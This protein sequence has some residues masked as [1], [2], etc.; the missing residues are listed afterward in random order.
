MRQ[1]ATTACTGALALAVPFSALAQPTPRFK[2]GAPGQLLASADGGL[3]W[4]VHTNFG[5]AIQIADIRQTG[6]STALKLRYQNRP[7][8]LSS[9]LDG[10]WHGTG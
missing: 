1:F 4:D 2:A 7:F 6:R 9:T 8:R 3:T 10:R 5:E